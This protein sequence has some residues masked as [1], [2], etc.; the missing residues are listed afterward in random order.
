MVDFLT[1]GLSKTPVQYSVLLLCFPFLRPRYSCEAVSLNKVPQTGVVTFLSVSWAT[2]AKIRIQRNTAPMLARSSRT[3]L[4]PLSCIVSDTP[5]QFL[6]NRQLPQFTTIQSTDQ[7][8]S[9]FIVN[10]STYGLRIES[11]ENNTL[12]GVNPM[13]VW[14]GLLHSGSGTVH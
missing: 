6:L 9:F 2:R 1:S 3:G 13:N 12:Y 5:T 8:P 11:Y 14:A 4:F 10:K 7:T